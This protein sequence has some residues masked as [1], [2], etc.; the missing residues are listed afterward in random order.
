MKSTRYG[1]NW[2]WLVKQLKV[3]TVSSIK[4]FAPRC[5]FICSVGFLHTLEGGFVELWLSEVLNPPERT[6][7][8]LQ[9]RSD[10]LSDCRAQEETEN[11]QC[12]LLSGTFFWQQHTVWA[13]LQLSARW[14][15]AVRHKRDN[16]TASDEAENISAE[17]PASSVCPTVKL[18][19]CLNCCCSHVFNAAPVLDP[20]YMSCL[21]I[22]TLR[23]N[24]LCFLCYE[25][26]KA[27]SSFSAADN[28]NNSRAAGSGEHIRRS[29]RTKICQRNEIF[30]RCLECLCLF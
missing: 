27:F 15:D 21:W 13:S 9:G 19:V 29:D 17:T 28:N 18:R 24:R 25:I 2:S 23:K 12:E 30:I 14:T 11:R 26:K 7:S 22:K 20:V 16:F 6:E 5:A 1:S 10:S 3:K 4:T 8:V